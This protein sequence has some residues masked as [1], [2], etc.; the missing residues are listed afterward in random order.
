MRKKLA[1][2]YYKLFPHYRVVERRV[3]SYREADEIIR[4]TCRLPESDRWAIDDFYEDLNSLQNI[5][6]LCR[7]ER[8]TE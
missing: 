4:L 6:Y 8:I 7:K 3:F 1:R 5:V 2:L